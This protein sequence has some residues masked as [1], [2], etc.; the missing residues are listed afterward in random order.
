MECVALDVEPFHLGI[1]DLDALSRRFWVS[2][3]L[4]ILRPV[5]VVVAAISSTT[6]TRSVSGRL[7]PVLRDVTEHAVLD[8]IPFRRTRR[9]VADLDREPRLVGELLQLDFPQPHTR[10]VR[11]AAVGRDRQLAGLSDSAAR[12]I[13]SSQVRMADTANSAVSCVMPTLTQPLFAAMS[14]TP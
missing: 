12:P 6:A 1:A 11:A 4:S 7:A 10:T 2:S 13:F 14:Y 9:I 8:L 5:F 3:A